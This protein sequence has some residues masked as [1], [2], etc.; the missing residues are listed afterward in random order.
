MA[1]GDPNRV[2]F[3]DVDGVLHPI[4]DHDL[5]PLGAD[6]DE[7]SARA[8]EG[9]VHCG[10]LG[11]VTRVLKEEFLATCM[12]ALLQIIEATDASIVLSTTWRKT[13]ADRAAVMAQLHAY[14]LAARVVGD[15]P[16]SGCRGGECREWLA[17]NRPGG[18]AY[19]VLDDDE[20]GVL[21]V[22][23][24]GNPHVPRSRFVCTVR[25]TGL[26]AQDAVAAIE[27]LQLPFGQAEGD[28][29]PVANGMNAAARQMLL[30]S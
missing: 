16:R 22:A 3:L 12:G 14:G 7:L 20:E 9:I 18:C 24:S 28:L 13:P 25:A 11:H 29:P 21:A 19:A 8:D 5:L 30:Y 15:T 6:L 26:T 1:A 10:E 27:M 4:G 23:P 17:S 2:I